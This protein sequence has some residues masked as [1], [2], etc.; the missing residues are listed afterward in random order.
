[1]AQNLFIQESL[2]QFIRRNLRIYVMMNSF[3]YTIKNPVLNKLFEKFIYHTQCY[4]EEYRQLK[5]LNLC[6]NILEKPHLIFSNDIVNQ[7]LT[8]CPNDNWRLLIGFEFESYKENAPMELKQLA[9]LKNATFGQLWKS[10]VYEMFH[11][12]IIHRTKHIQDLLRE[13]YTESHTNV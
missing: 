4:L 3:Y 13:I 2:D 6:R 9:K 8:F 1:M 10:H 11:T 12:E 5:R 7:L